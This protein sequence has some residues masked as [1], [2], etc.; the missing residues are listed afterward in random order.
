M[1]A[2]ENTLCWLSVNKNSW[3]IKLVQLIEYFMKVL[4]KKRF[5]NPPWPLVLSHFLWIKSRHTCSLRI[6][7]RKKKARNKSYGILLS[8]FDGIL[9]IFWTYFPCLIFYGVNFQYRNVPPSSNWTKYARV[10]WVNF[11][12]DSL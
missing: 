9:K 3:T 4:I 1:I 10:D 5:R 8:R 11:V 2:L 7:F 12:E 6:P